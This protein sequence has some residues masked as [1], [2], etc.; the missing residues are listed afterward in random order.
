MLGGLNAD[1]EQAHNPR[2]QKV[3]GI[4]MEFG[5]VDLLH[6]FRQHWKFCH[7]KIWSQLQ[8]FMLFQTK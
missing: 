4:L 2:S 7:M 8:R 1:I 3:P 5:M 6:Y